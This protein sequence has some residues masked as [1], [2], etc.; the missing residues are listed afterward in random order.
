M[1]NGHALAVIAAG[2]GLLSFAQS[3]TRLNLKNANHSP[4]TRGM[5]HRELAIN[6]VLDEDI[7]MDLLDKEIEIR[8][9]IFD[10]FGYREDWRVLPFC[11]AR[12]YYWCLCGE[13]PDSVLYAETEQGLED[14]DHHIISVYRQR[15]LSKF[16]YRGTDYT[17]IVVD[18]H[19]DGNKF[20]KIFDNQK[21]CNC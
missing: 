16:I 20:L 11:D 12:G 21:E 13:E 8:R 7:N 9:Q 2:N 14:G 4:L 15:H 5:A 18:T 17:M 3:I 1:G 19:C 6:R 10:Y